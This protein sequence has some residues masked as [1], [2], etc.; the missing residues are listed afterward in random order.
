MQ[1]GNVLVNMSAF[2]FDRARSSQPAML[3]ALRASSELSSSRRGPV[4]P[5][6]RRSHGT[7]SPSSSSGSSATTAVSRAAAPALSSG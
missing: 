2:H 1:R 3:T 6:R 5:G 4:S 7:D